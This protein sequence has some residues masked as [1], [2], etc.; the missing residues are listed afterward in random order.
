MAVQIPVT[1]EYNGRE[2]KGIFFGCL[3]FRQPDLAPIG[4]PLSLGQLIYSARLGW[5][6]YDPKEEMRN[7]SDYF[8]D[9]AM[10]WYE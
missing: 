2:C 6:F 8:G 5:Q 1:F 3:R 9:V 7:Y 4:E 10:A